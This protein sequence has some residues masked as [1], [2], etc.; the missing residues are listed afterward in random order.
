LL[1]YEELLKKLAIG[2]DGFSGAAIAGVSRAAASRGELIGF[3]Y[4]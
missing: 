1:S 3:H 2:C 4:C